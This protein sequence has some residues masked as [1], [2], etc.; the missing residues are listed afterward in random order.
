MIID[1]NSKPLKLLS[2][3]KP[4]Y[5]VKG[6]EYKKNNI[7]PKTREEIK[8]LSKFGGE[9]LFSP[10]DVIYSSTAIQKIDK[11][12]LN[13]EKLISLMEFEKI[14]SEL[15]TTIKNLRKLNPYNWGYD[16]R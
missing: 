8:V 16:C 9:I 15:E 2:K 5:F 14:S 1:Y 13:Y 10:G 6:F 11:P 7:H 4:N 3:L 12:N